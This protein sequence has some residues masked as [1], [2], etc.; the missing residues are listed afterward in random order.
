MARP[1]GHSRACL[2]SALGPAVKDALVVVALL[3][4][5]LRQIS[6]VC[7]LQNFMSMTCVAEC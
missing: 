5:L 6:S 7:S 3:A 4:L 1:W 2:A